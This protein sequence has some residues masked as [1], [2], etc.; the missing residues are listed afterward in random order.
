MPVSTDKFNMRLIVKNE[1]GQVDYSAAVKAMGAI[2]A[3][4]LYS[5]GQGTP[6]LKDTESL[7]E[8]ILRY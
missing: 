4:G 7:R 2:K 5:V 6:N 3:F 1:A 8:L